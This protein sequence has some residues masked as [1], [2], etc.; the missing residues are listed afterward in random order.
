MVLN[1]D[2]YLVGPLQLTQC[3]CY[4]ICFWM[5]CFKEVHFNLRF[6]FDIS[7]LY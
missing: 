1:K 5:E 6:E 3:N 7:C 4:R 2:C